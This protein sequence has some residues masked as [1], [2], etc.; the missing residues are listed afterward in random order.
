MVRNALKQIKIWIVGVWRF[1]SLRT[2]CYKILIDGILTQHCSF[3]NQSHLIYTQI[4][5]TIY[6]LQPFLLTCKSKSK[7]SETRNALLIDLV[8]LGQIKVYFPFSKPPWSI[9]LGAHRYIMPRHMAT[10]LKCQA[11]W[12]MA[13]N[14]HL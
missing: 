14:C 8:F 4:N 3:T 11:Y 12:P 7:Y 10:S 9:I 13:L 5:E 6:I 2:F 1:H